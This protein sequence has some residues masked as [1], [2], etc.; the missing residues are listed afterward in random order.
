MEELIKQLR[1]KYFKSIADI[2]TTGKAEITVTI[3]DEI[4]AENFSQE[5][6]DHLVETI[7]E[8]SIVKINIVDCQGTLIDSFATNQ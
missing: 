2:K 8:L 5:L 7:D 3:A 6:Q 4:N 1:D